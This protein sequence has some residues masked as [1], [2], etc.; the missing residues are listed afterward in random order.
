MGIVEIGVLVYIGILA[1]IAL[2]S[3]RRVAEQL[4]KLK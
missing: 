1:A 2:K 4:N 3:R